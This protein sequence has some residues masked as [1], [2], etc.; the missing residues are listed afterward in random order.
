VDR[1]VQKQPDRIDHGVAAHDLPA[2]VH[3][4]QIRDADLMHRDAD[5][6]DPEVIRKLWIAHRDVAQQ[7]LRL[8]ASPEDPAGRGQS[9]QR[10][11]ALGFL[12]L[13][14]GRTRLAKL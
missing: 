10:M 2:M 13:D 9:L 11:H 6:V 7:T 12:C 4:D 5:R 14:T 3:L 8:A 1:G